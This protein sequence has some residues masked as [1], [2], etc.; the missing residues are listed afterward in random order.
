M[1]RKFWLQEKLENIREKSARDHVAIAEEKTIWNRHRT[2]IS[3]KEIE[4]NGDGA[5]IERGR[6]R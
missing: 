1:F 4:W 5:E 2:D 3:L 6:T